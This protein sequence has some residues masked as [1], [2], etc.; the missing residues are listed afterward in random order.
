MP[1]KAQMS[2]DKALKRTP[3]P[4][5]GIIYTLTNSANGMCYV[6][7]TTMSVHDRCIKHKNKATHQPN[8]G[9]RLLHAAIKEHGLDSFEKEVIAVHLVADLDRME[10]FH[11]QRVGSLAP[12]GYNLELGGHNGEKSTVTKQKMSKTRHA[13]NGT[14]ERYDETIPTCIHPRKGGYEITRHPKC[15]YKRFAD[16]NL[17][18]EENF[19][20]CMIHYQFI[21]NLMAKER[22]EIFD[23]MFDDWLANAG[24]VEETIG[25]MEKPALCELLKMEEILSCIEGYPSADITPT[26]ISA[27]TIALQA[28]DALRAP[29]KSYVQRNGQNGWKVQKMINGAGVMQCNNRTFNDKTLTD[30]QNRANAD[31]F[32]DFLY[33]NPNYVYVGRGKGTSTGITKLD[34]KNKGFLVT[35]KIDG[36]T[37][38]KSFT[39]ANISMKQKR[40]LAEEFLH[41]KKPP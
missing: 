11:I 25:F 21:E 24:D 9:A 20:A 32:V 33:E 28:N 1:N 38:Y 14:P 7:Q 6:G 39:D 22:K 3:D 23:A 12:A 2:S 37:K 40:I 5:Y 4:G 8:V 19:S 41:S 30:E 18:M 16:P 26:I 31:T 27:Q 15:S 17:S 34:G 29:T 36:V 35:F 10:V 13:N